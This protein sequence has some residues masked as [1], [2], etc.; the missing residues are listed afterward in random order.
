[1][2]LNT[3][4]YWE[5]TADDFVAALASVGIVNPTTRNVRI[6]AETG[7]KVRISYDEIEDGVSNVTVRVLN[8]ADANGLERLTAA[9]LRAPST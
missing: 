1:M 2:M 5:V 4:D 3:T 8:G 7:D 9:S 6:T